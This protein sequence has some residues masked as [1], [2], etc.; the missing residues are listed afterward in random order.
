M[1]LTRM[2]YLG[3]KS[4][5]WCSIA[6]L[7][8]RKRIRTMRTYIYLLVALLLTSSGFLKAQ[9]TPTSDPVLPYTYPTGFNYQAM[10]YLEG[11]PVVNTEVALQLTLQD[12][13]GI[14]YL[15]EKHKV[16]TSPT[17]MVDVMV[18]SQSPNEITN[19]PWE[20]ALSVK[21]EVDIAGG[22]NYTQ[23]GVVKLAPVPYALHAFSAPLIRGTGDKENPIFQVQNSM[24][25]P[26]F[27]VYE[28]AV[29]FNVSE[30]EEGLRRPRG[31]FAIRSVHRGADGALQLANR[32]EFADGRVDIY[33]DPALRRPRGGFA[34]HTQLMGRNNTKPTTTPLFTMNDRSTLFTIDNCEV[35]SVFQFRDR[36]DNN[37]VVMNFTQGGNIQ[38]A[39]GSTTNDVV[40][41]LP[42]PQHTQMNINWLETGDDQ[43]LPTPQ[44]CTFTNL[45]RW[46]VPYVVVDNKRGAPYKIEIINSHDA[47]KKLTDYLTV[48]SIQQ[49]IKRASNPEK[50][51]IKEAEALMLK[52]DFK[53][54]RT[55][56]L[57]AGTI[58]IHWDEYPNVYKDISSADIRLVAADKL[59]L[60]NSFV[61]DI[62]PKAT[63]GEL[64]I[65]SEGLS[66]EAYWPDIAHNLALKVQI[67]DQANQTFSQCLEIKQVSGPKFK[68]KI[69]D[70][71]AFY[72]AVL[73][74]PGDFQKY[75]KKVTLKCKL[76]FP[77]ALYEDEELIIDLH[78]VKRD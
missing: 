70:P 27:S 63:E 1:E 6:N 64:E 59:T 61:D 54:T 45:A 2:C 60:K 16:K 43:P 69:L 77:N 55:T 52:E 71:K 78:V 25:L 40:G 29:R 32:F 46:R 23:L 53:I 5:S 21:V 28:D 19:V 9:N 65:Q 13:K 8:Q 44:T 35:G 72:A 11:K 74:E 7:I 68:L 49:C 12:D 4:P 33:V 75:I 66:P 18:G 41:K 48:G 57:P 37:N 56:S 50:Y 58:R 15:V 31:G 51:D 26:I 62:P 38:S 47:T 20:K 24:G 67:V 39:K 22:T 34:I 17:G 76:I 10:I 30:N 3:Y 36:K 73:K 42:D 14:A